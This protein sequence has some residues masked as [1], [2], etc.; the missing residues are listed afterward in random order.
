MNEI[1]IISNVTYHFEERFR[2]PHLDSLT[3]D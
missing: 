2:C 1:E 3:F